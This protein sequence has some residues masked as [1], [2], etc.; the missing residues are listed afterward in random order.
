MTDDRAQLRRRAAPGPVAGADFRGGAGAGARPARRQMV[1]QGRE[2]AHHGQVPGA[3]RRGASWRRWAAE[4]A[5][6]LAPLPR[7]RLELRRMGAFPSARQANVLWAGA[8]DVEHGLAAVAEVVEGVCERLGFARERRPFT[9]H[10]TVGR[11]KGRGVDAAR[12]AGRVRRR[13]MSSRSAGRPSKRFTSTRAAWVARAPRT[14]CGRGPHSLPTD[15]SHR[16]HDMATTT[17]EK[18]ETKLEKVE[19]EDKES[20]A[21]PAI[22][23]ARRRS[24]SPS[25]R[26]RSSSARGASCASARGWPRPR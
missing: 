17:T 4:L 21:R 15:N 14:F 3:G 13:E 24:T 20:R 26:S 22:P 7:F 18:S 19:K 11:A 12:R 16:R 25:R 6:A 5:Q 8:D 23:C 9:G 10:V 2:P 1:A